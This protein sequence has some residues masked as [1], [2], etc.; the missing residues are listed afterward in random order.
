MKGV[1]LVITIV[2]YGM[3]N[4]RSVYN[5]LKALNAD[6]T[7][8]DKPAM[9]EKADKLVLPGVGAFKDT[10]DELHKRKL[11][12][13]VRKFIASGRPYLGM[14]LGLQILFDESEEGASGVDGLGIFKGSVKKFK[15]DKGCKI[16]HMGWNTVAFSGGTEPL[17]AGIPD[18]SYFYFVHSYYADP[19]DKGIIAGRTEYCGVDFAAYVVKDNI[20]AVQFHPERSQMLGLKFLENFVRL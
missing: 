18:R 9:V 14:C 10:M 5:A 16:P 3:G 15:P 1:R 7:V 12:S 4:L 6:V 11:V 13:P 17:N 8:S 2:D 19:V 20:Y